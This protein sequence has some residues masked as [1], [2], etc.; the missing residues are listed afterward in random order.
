MVPAPSVQV[1]LG[2]NALLVDHMAPRE[3]VEPEGGVIVEVEVRDP[4]A[5]TGA[6]ARALL[7]PTA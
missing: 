7:T 5:R 4:A 3:P 2:A 1:R 6:E